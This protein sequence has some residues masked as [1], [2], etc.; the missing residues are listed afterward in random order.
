MPYLE[1]PQPRDS[2]CH[3]PGCDLRLN[4]YGICPN[5]TK[6][7]EEDN[8]RHERYERKK[9]QRQDQLQALLDSVFENKPIPPF[10]TQP[11]THVWENYGDK[12]LCCKLCGVI[13][14]REDL[15]ENNNE[16]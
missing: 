15:E 3:R 12:M 13:I 10:L 6:H 4:H 9:K 1:Y 8:E 11:S 2:Y 5:Q 16:R 14:S 7:L